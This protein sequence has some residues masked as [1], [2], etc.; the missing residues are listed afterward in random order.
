MSGALLRTHMPTRR[1]AHPLGAAA[2]C[3][4]ALLLIPIIAF[5]QNAR[6]AKGRDING[7]VVDVDSSP[8]ANATVSVAGGGPSATTGADGSFKL[9]GVATTNVMVDVKIGRAHV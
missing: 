3:A 5:A 7:T 1:I 4:L 6:P 2:V 8:V 9:T